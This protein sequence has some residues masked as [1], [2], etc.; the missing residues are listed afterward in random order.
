MLTCPSEGL[1]KCQSQRDSPAWS[2]ALD[3]DDP[4]TIS[5]LVCEAHR[6]INKGSTLLPNKT[7]ITHCYIHYSKAQQNE[8]Y[9]KRLR[10]SSQRI[11]LWV[12]HNPW[13]CI[14]YFHS[15][16]LRQWV[17]RDRHEKSGKICC[18]TNRPLQTLPFDFTAESFPKAPSSLTVIQRHENKLT[19]LTI[20][21]SQHPLILSSY[22]RS[23]VNSPLTG[24]LIL[25][26]HLKQKGCRSC[27][28]CDEVSLDIICLEH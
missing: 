16:L 18:D 19:S 22:C 21:A 2:G 26:W 15:S 17:K 4:H 8:T 27:P 20:L 12:R 14:Q 3:E 24:R 25:M 28:P 10:N 7:E 6:S 9:V 5:H 23:S 1:R 13:V 11:S